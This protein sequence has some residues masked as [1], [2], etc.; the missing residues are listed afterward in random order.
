M[1]KFQGNSRLRLNLKMSKPFDYRGH[2]ANSLRNRV[3]DLD[4]TVQIK[5]FRRETRFLRKY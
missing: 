2:Y 1:T 3:S 4:Q 5:I